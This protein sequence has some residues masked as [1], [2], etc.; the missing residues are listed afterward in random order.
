MSSVISDWLNK[1]QDIQVVEY[2]SYTH[3]ETRYYSPKHE[4]KQEYYD[5]RIKM[6]HKNPNNLSILFKRKQQ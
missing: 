6:S 5:K 2:Y 3:G 4:K 1:L